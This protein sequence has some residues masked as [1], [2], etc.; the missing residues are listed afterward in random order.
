MAVNAARQVIAC[1]VIERRAMPGAQRR[2]HFPGSPGPSVLAAPPCLLLS[3]IA[4]STMAVAALTGR[5][6]AHGKS[7]LGKRTSACSA[8]P[9]TGNLSRLSSAVLNILTSLIASFRPYA[10]LNALTVCSRKSVLSVRT[11]EGCNDAP[12][13]DK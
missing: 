11:T 3:T 7:N 2:R 1:R 8:F 12:V 10:W 9:Q 6:P 4:R 5:L 13:P